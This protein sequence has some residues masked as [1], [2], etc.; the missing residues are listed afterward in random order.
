MASM[1]DRDHFKEVTVRTQVSPETREEG[2]EVFSE[3][4]DRLSCVP[5][6]DQQGG[7]QRSQQR[8]TPRRQSTKLKTLKHEKTGNQGQLSAAETQGSSREEMR[9]KVEEPGCILQARSH[10]SRKSPI[11]SVF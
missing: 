6:D 1:G 4:S 2:R 7:R 10:C 9:D 8:G 11:T 5:R 3:E